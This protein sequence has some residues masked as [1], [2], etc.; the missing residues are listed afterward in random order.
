MFIDDCMFANLKLSLHPHAHVY[1][2]HEVEADSHSSRALLGSVQPP[3]TS[4]VLQHLLV[5]A[6]RVG[7]VA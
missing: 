7:L 2:P 1:T 6:T 3:A 4:D 5:G